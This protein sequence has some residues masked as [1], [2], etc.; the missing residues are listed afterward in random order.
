[1]R[2][3]LPLTLVRADDRPS[4][5]QLPATRAIVDSG[6]DRTTL[7]A[8]WARLLGID[9]IND[10]VEDK[11]ITGGGEATHYAFGGGIWAD[12]LGEQ[13]LIPLVSFA[14]M[15]PFAFLGR[16]DFF[17][18]YLVVVDQ[19]GKRFFLERHPDREEDEDDDP[20]VVLVAS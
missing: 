6:A 2:P 17:E 4:T 7:P 1:M 8:H 15:L 20:D 19:R 12:L 14:P 16:D 11:T 9:L 5:T 18:R 3:T 13:I 10:C